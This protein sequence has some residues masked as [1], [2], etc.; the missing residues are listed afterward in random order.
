MRFP[1]IQ[2]RKFY[3]TNFIFE[4]ERLGLRRFEVSDGEDFAEILTDEETS[5]FEP[6]DTFTYENAIKEAEKLA[7]DERFFAVII[8]ETGKL[9]GKI[10][11]EDK[12]F[13][14]TWEIGYS[15]NRKYWGNGYALEA[16]KGV[17]N[18]AFS[19]MNVRRIYA[20]ADVLNTR[21]I[22]LLERAGLRRE[23][24]FIKSA[25]FKKDNNG[26]PIWGDFASYA[27]LKDEYNGKN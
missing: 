10:Y 16:V 15:F 21:S 27:I 26:E 9:V 25:Y 7:G 23:G 19:E 4:T 18:Y 2:I 11:F 13:F 6:Y 3:M 17:I 12:K 22:K 20:E 14:G 5:Y 24:V 1:K 8:K